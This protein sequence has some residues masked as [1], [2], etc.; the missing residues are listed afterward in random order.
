MRSVEFFI[1]R[2]HDPRED[3]RGFAFERRHLIGK[4]GLGLVG[5][6]ASEEII[7]LSPENYKVYGKGIFKTRATSPV[8]CLAKSFNVEVNDITEANASISKFIASQLSKV[9]NAQKEGR[10]EVGNSK[11]AID[12]KTVNMGINSPLFS[13]DNTPVYISIPCKITVG[14]KDFFRTVKFCVPA[15]K[16]KACNDSAAFEKMA[17]EIM[18]GANFDY[19]AHESYGEA[20]RSAEAFIRVG[21]TSLLKVNNQVRDNDD[22]SFL[23]PGVK[24][25]T[26]FSIPPK[27]KFSLETKTVVNMSPPEDDDNTGERLKRSNEELNEV[28]RRLLAAEENAKKNNKELDNVKRNLEDVKKRLDDSNNRGIVLD[29]EVVNLTKDLEER[30]S[31]VDKMKFEIEAKIRKEE[32]DKNEKTKLEDAIARQ[33]KEIVDMNVKI[34]NYQKVVTEFTF[35]VKNLTI[36]IEKAQKDKDKA[37][38][39]FE[40]AEKRAKVAEDKLKIANEK[41]IVFK[42]RIGDLQEELRRKGVETEEE[43]RKLMEAKRNAEE[44]L[45]RVKKEAENKERKLR[46]Q[47]TSLNNE[48]KGATD[49][50]SAINK[51]LENVRKRATK[52]ENDKEVAEEKMRNILLRIKFIL[53]KTNITLEGG[54]EELIKQLDGAK[55]EIANLR[56]QLKEADENAR[57]QISDFE[58][59]MEKEKSE[60]DRIAKEL[61]AVKKELLNARNDLKDVTKLN[62]LVKNLQSK[63]AEKTDEIANLER[64]IIEA[65]EKNRGVVQEL[66][67]MIDTKNSE[68]MKKD[69]NIS[70]IL[71]NS[72]GKDARIDELEE[73][74]QKERKKIKDSSTREREDLAKI[75]GLEKEL[76]EYKTENANLKRQLEDANRKLSEERENAAKT[77]TEADENL[78]RVTDTLKETNLRAKKEKETFENEIK[79]LTSE[80]R[81]ESKK[82]KSFEDEVNDLKSNLAKAEEERD[83]YGNIIRDKEE[84]NKVLLSKI[85]DLNSKIKKG[86]EENDELV[87][88]N[89]DLEEQIERLSSE[90]REKEQEITNFKG[91][92]E[93]LKTKMNE[94]REKITRL[95][96][97]NQEL[98]AKNEKKRR[99][100]KRLEAEKEGFVTRNKELERENE[101][102]KRK[103][104]EK[105]REMK[106]ALK[107]KDDELAKKDQKIRKQSDRITE[108]KRKVAELEQNSPNLVVI[109]DGE[110]AR[111]KAEETTRKEKTTDGDASK[112]LQYMPLSEYIIYLNKQRDDINLQPRYDTTILNQLLEK[113]FREAIQSNVFIKVD[114]EKRVIGI[115]K[116]DEKSS[117][118]YRDIFKRNKGVYYP[119]VFKNG[120]GTVVEVESSNVVVYD[121]VAAAL[122]IGSALEE[123]GG[124]FQ[125]LRL[126]SGLRRD[127]ISEN[128]ELKSKI[129][130]EIIELSNYENEPVIDEGGDQRVRVAI[131]KFNKKEKAKKGNSTCTVAFATT[132]Y[133][134]NNGDRS[135]MESLKT[136]RELIEERM[137]VVPIQGGE[138][139]GSVLGDAPIK[140][141]KVDDGVESEEESSRSLFGALALTNAFIVNGNGRE[142]EGVSIDGR[143]TMTLRRESL[144][145]HPGDETEDE[146]P[147]QQKDF[148]ERTCK[149]FRF[150]LEEMEF[151]DERRVETVVLQR[152]VQS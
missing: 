26:T 78:K 76:D 88:K 54:L 45:I 25:N 7:Y 93:D 109:R 150:N 96:N 138:E 107:Q 73:Q 77:K 123:K 136:N 5:P 11:C 70:V 21:F 134:A 8:Y 92:A 108:L 90:L 99:V 6:G 37:N 152:N 115:V 53:N 113:E 2:Y 31:A 42:K 56:R 121:K 84:K 50:V 48:K 89:R 46:E 28:K 18:A 51:E 64:R 34:N 60:K 91:E 144:L 66:R 127:I 75:A 19:R 116:F 103:L 130:V 139:F 49:G 32:E 4:G 71:K 128:I 30:K 44:E 40:E 20:F 143:A 126:L 145:P 27:P 147:K 110:E 41:I 72:K 69:E 82:A 62:L 61:E 97:E 59:K 10:K 14:G 80:K 137:D 119:R 23:S 65:D 125:A 104:R 79:K 38:R 133:N 101:S 111:K 151:S 13:S 146:A 12:G 39:D 63:L 118:T 106:E 17:E 114:A 142:N 52:A 117:Q 102:L 85:S 43:Y 9:K 22:V 16:I 67:V 140:V 57:R 124:K 98:N 86:K 105:E 95:K 55:F 83:R 35:E 122:D 129:D 87:Q 47:I 1:K 149:L 29:E 3:G 94:L 148:L 33:K 141:M 135:S 120:V 36:L 132:L 74:L 58:Q 112:K 15:K 81:V 24:Q 100:I 68:I 131:E